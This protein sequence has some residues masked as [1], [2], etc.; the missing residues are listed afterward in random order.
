M[1]ASRPK[2]WPR[3]NAAKKVA[4]PARETV[5][6]ASKLL[7]FRRSG[8]DICLTR[9]MDV[10]RH[11]CNDPQEIVDYVFSEYLELA[12]SPQEHALVIGVDSRNVVVGSWVVGQ[13]PENY[14]PV[15]IPSVLR[16][17]IV[18]GMRALV[19][20]HNHP[21][22]QSEPSEADVQLTEKIAGACRE[23]GVGFLDHV[24]VTAGK[25]RWTSLRRRGLPF[26]GDN[27]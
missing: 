13:G 21:S 18:L 6:G 15:S 11:T 7:D 2:K 3:R 12:R 9:N 4:A 27:Q 22:G 10:P 23:F 5:C 14:A 25:S 1:I 26:F 8:V 16:P 24:I 17:A 19:L 20:V